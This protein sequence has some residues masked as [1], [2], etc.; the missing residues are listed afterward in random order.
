MLSERYSKANNKYLTHYNPL[1][2]SIFILDP[3]ANNLYGRVMQEYLPYKS[4]F[5]MQPSELGSQIILKNTAKYQIG[6]ILECA[7][8]YPASLYDHYSDCCLESVKVRNH[9]INN[10]YMLGNI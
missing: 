10:P 2:S 8:L 1:K 3:D 5:W 4:F 6:Y 7:L 9:T